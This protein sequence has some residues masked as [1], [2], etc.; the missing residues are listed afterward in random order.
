MG[1][2]LITGVGA[3]GV[4]WGGGVGGAVTTCCPRFLNAST[5]STVILPLGPDP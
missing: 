2:G 4:G 5:S 1:V 3:T